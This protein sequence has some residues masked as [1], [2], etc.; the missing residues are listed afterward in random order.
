M[1][2]GTGADRLFSGAGD[3]QLSGGRDGNGVLDGEQDLFVYGAG[4]WGS[5]RIVSEFE[6]GFDLF[7]LRESGLG[8]EDL[9]IVDAPFR[10]TITSSL[11]QIDIFES[12]DEPVEITADDFLF[13]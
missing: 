12:F 7:D 4:P 3:D 2:G 9:T 11:G 6:D 8:F 10:T 13:A 5:D 1:Q